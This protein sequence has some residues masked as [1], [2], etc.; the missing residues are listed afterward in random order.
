MRGQFPPREVVPTEE[1][2]E[3]E[4]NFYTN[5]LFLALHSTEAMTVTISRI[6]I[7]WFRS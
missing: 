1:E 6:S 5:I 4:V 3:E 7:T 2:E